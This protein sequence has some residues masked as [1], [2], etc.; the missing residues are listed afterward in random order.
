MSEGQYLA[1]SESLIPKLRLVQRHLLTAL[2][3]IVGLTAVPS[4][5]ATLKAQ[6][7]NG[8]QVGHEQ[9][10]TADRWEDAAGEK[11]AF[12]VASVRPDK[13]ERKPFSNVKLNNA[14]EAYPPN[15]G[16][17]T[18]RNWNLVEYMVFAYKLSI[19]QANIVIPSLPRWAVMDLF[20]I[21]AKSDNHNPTKDQ[22]RLML[23]ALLE[24]RFKLVGHRETRQLPVFGLVLAKPGKTGPQLRPHSADS[25]CPA[26]SSSSSARSASVETVLKTWPTNC[27]HVRGL[28]RPRSLRLA[29]RNVSMGQ[30]ADALTNNGEGIGSRV[31]VDQTGLTGTFDFVL[32]FAKESEHPADEE[33]TE[34]G[35]VPSFLAAVTDQLGLKL[36]KKTAPTDCFVVVHVERPSAN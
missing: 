13:S 35:P 25:P 14:R 15:G 33:V 20:D 30:L 32:D 36:V 21:E 16:V 23:Q 28:G 1:M 12:D 3:L 29:G 6:T 27:G 31:I 8:E 18:A 2:V 19:Q 34:T 11:M 10:S 9:T 26:E 5:S 4:W 22:M 7:T 24:D 17:F